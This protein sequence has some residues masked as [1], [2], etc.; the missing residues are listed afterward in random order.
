MALVKRAR[1]VR[2]KTWHPT[3]RGQGK[4]TSPD[5]HAKGPNSTRESAGRAIAIS[6]LGRQLSAGFAGSPGVA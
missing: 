6:P 4:W 5:F 1:G 2:S 3:D